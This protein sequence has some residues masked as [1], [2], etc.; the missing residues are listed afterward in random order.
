MVE[1]EDQRATDLCL[2]REPRLITAGRTSLHSEH[3][4]PIKPAAPA[5]YW[6]LNFDPGEANCSLDLVPTGAR[7][8]ARNTSKRST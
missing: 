8:T 6:L 3:Q 7:C 5:A 1:L 4:K 2:S